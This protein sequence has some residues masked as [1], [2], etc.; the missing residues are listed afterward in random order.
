MSALAAERR[1][2]GA[3][4]TGRDDHRSARGCE[5]AN[6]A[7]VIPVVVAHDDVAKRL[8]RHCSFQERAVVRGD[9]ARRTRAGNGLEADERFRRIEGDDEVAKLD[10]HHDEA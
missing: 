1:G 10:E 3:S 5:L 4:M 6:S 2:R 7:E 8:S 9:R